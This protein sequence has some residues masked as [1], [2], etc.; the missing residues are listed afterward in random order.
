MF[1]CVLDRLG[2]LRRVSWLLSTVCS[3]VV[4][5]LAEVAPA[6][7]LLPMVTMVVTTQPSAILTAAIT[8]PSHHCPLCLTLALVLAKTTPCVALDIFFGS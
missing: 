7:S 2:A 8:T 3:V 6:A 4:L 1:T 5:H